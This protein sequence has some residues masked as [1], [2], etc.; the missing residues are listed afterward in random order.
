MTKFWKVIF[1][2]CS[3]AFILTTFYSCVG[4]SRS[5]TKEHY[6]S[7]EERAYRERLRIK[8]LY[9]QQIEAAAYKMAYKVQKLIAPKSGKEVGYKVNYNNLTYDRSNHKVTV[10]A[11]FSFLA[12]DFWSGVGYGTCLIGGVLDVYLP[13]RNIDGTRAI[14]IWKERNKQ[15]VNVSKPRHWNVLNNGLSINF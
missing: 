8:R 13:V 3:F 7:A 11:D 15:I 4:T 10:Y 14:F 1:I 2:V 6:L 12:R 5:S 9:G